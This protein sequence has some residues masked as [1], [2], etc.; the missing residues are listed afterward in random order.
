MRLILYLMLLLS[1]AAHAEATP[2]RSATAADAN[3]NAAR[4]Q[5][6]NRKLPLAKAHLRAVED[7]LKR[8][9][10]V[11]KQY[12]E[13]AGNADIAGQS[14]RFIELDTKGKAVFPR[15]TVLDQCGS[16][17]TAA[18]ELWMAR[19]QASKGPMNKQSYE[20]AHK[21]WLDT[22]RGCQQQMNDPS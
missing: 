17:G 9:D 3:G 22:Q 13:Q 2:T 5:E 4:I 11:L 18:Y 12:V 10:A 6:F 7:E 21:F 19:L 1:V 14:G 8:S 16:L 15:W 20:W